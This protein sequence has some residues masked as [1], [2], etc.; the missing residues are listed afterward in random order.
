MPGKKGAK[1]QQKSSEGE[2]FVARPHASPFEE[3]ETTE[4]E[5][6]EIETKTSPEVRVKHQKSIS[7]FTFFL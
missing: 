5:F 3:S 1:K 2:P 7:L 6:S 4:N